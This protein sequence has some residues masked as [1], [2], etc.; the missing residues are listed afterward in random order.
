[1]D[2]EHKEDDW[3]GIMLELPPKLMI[4]HGNGN[5]NKQR[6]TTSGSR[7]RLSE[8]VK[9]LVAI[10]DKYIDFDGLHCVNISYECRKQCDESMNEMR[11][12]YY[13]SVS[14]M[15]MSR[16]RLSIIR[17]HNHADD[18][19]MIDTRKIHAQSDRCLLMIRDAIGQFD[20]AFLEV[21]SM[22]QRDS[23]QRF[24]NTPQF[25]KWNQTLEI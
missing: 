13:R 16:S 12:E 4:E 24:V 7:F 10:Y 21:I 9:R 23:F 17:A 25:H 5:G 14:V 19:L 22:I 3:I 15:S 6:V 20:K 11:N 1:M 8:C 18:A 2:S